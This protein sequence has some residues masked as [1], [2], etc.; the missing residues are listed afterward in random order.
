MPAPR[1]QLPKAYLRIDPDIDH[2]H[3]DHLDEFI[4]LLCAGNRQVPRGRFKSRALLGQLFGRATVDRFFQR[5]DVAPEDDHLVI[6]GWDFW[7]EGD[8]TVAER[9]R[10]YRASKGVTDRNGTVTE[11]V[12][13]DV[14]ERNGGVTQAVTKAVTE[15]VTVTATPSE[16]LGRKTLGR[17]DSLTG[18]DV[19]LS[20]QGLSAK[21][22]RAREGGA[23]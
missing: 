12:T 4:R 19:T 18:D 23:A 5:G 17:R 20:G 22:A 13:E 1:Q 6:L 2:K 14:T 16:A 3:P 15:G 10:R 7:Q 21:P 8:L 11:D 9:M